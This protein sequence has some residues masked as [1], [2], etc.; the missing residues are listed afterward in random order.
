MNDTDPFE[1]DDSEDDE[2]TEVFASDPPIPQQKGVHPTVS[3]KPIFIVVILA[4]FCAASLSAALMVSV[5]AT[6]MIYG[7]SMQH[8]DTASS[9]LS[10][11]HHPSVSYAISD[12]TILMKRYPEITCFCMHH[13]ETPPEIRNYQVCMARPQKN[14]PLVE[15]LINPT[16]EGSSG[17][18]I[19]L[20]KPCSADK[21][22]PKG[23]SCVH[24]STSV[25]C[26][27]NSII[28]PVL[29][30]KQIK[31]SYNDYEGNPWW[32]VYKGPAAFCLQRSIEE[33]N[34]NLKCQ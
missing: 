5:P 13:L 19:N 29:R 12:L 20:S 14:S 8:K 24:T 9:T 31:I 26:P 33:M 6:T 17:A 15:M 7:L 4:F 16:L 30:A 11:H 2:D 23:M 25:A 27:Q 32:A 3:L 1:D 10:N 28:P 18:E 34:T 22:V 21:P